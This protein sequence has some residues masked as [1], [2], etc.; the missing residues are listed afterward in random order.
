MILEKILFNLI[1]FTLFVILF[2]KIIQKNDTSYLLILAIQFIGI[3]LN[4]IELF[5]EAYWN[6][7]TRILVYIFAI[8]IPLAILWL[9]RIG[10]EFSEIYHLFLAK[11]LLL[12]K[13]EEQA[14]N[15]LLKII[16]KNPNRSKA[17][18]MLAQIYEMQKKYEIAIEEYTRAYELQV[19][20]HESGY[21]VAELSNQIGKNQEAIQVLYQL[22]KQKPEE[23]RV[24]NLLGNIL[25]EEERYKEA[26]SVYQDA[27]KYHPDEYE[28]Y[29]QMGMAYT[30]LNDFQK[31]KEF[32]EKAA[33]L[34]SMLYHAK[35]DIAQIAL[36]MGDFEEAKQYFM[37]CIQNENTELG[38]YY[39]LA[40]I[41]VVKGDLDNAILYMN[42]AIELDST[43]Y[44]KIREEEI[45]VKI[46]NRVKKPAKQEKIEIKIGKREKKVQDHL[47]KMYSLVGDLNH[48]EM[49]M[50]KNVKENQAKEIKEQKEIEERGQDF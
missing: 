33:Y 28:I 18:R 16:D 20:D 7:P 11:L 10:Y 2:F 19:G 49:Q 34:N 35:Y 12:Q 50:M 3:L 6:L 23:Y 14:K 37:E 22:A 13:K 25:Q 39:Y 32:Y 41:S 1:A 48:T 42:M 4:F 47:E 40:L 26:L 29:Y 36:I 5:T 21:K 15:Y 8:I 46:R 27:L 44:E 30:M 45:F 43:V 38:S 31:A 9:E 17:H 24:T